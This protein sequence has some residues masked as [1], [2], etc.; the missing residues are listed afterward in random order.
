MKKEKYFAWFQQK[1]KFSLDCKKE[2]ILLVAHYSSE[3]KSTLE[4][5]LDGTIEE[6]SYKSKSK[7]ASGG[8]AKSVPKPKDIHAEE[9]KRFEASLSNREIQLKSMYDEVRSKK[10]GAMLV[11]YLKSGKISPKERDGLGRCPLILAVD[12]EF[13]VDTCKQL[14]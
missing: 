9:N 7:D 4:S 5:V 12:C 3:L 13:G 6:V 11:Q 8:F 14:V 10:D 1:G 2:Y